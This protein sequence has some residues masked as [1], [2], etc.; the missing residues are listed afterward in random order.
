MR[1]RVRAWIGSVLAL[2]AAWPGAAEPW[3]LARI[4]QLPDSAF[5]AVE[6]A[7]DGRRLRHL[8]H[9]DESGAVDPA[10]LRAAR[11]RLDQVRWLDPARREEARRHLEA[12][13]RELRGP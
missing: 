5:A 2:L 4:R 13:W 3:S 12:H 1:P 8:P 7:P 11:A 6:T 9:H 10:H